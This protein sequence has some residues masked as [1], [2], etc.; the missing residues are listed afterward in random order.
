MKNTLP[1]F[2]IPIILLSSCAGNIE[3]PIEKHYETFTVKNGSLTI[4]DTLIASVEGEN[5][6]ELA[7]KAGGRIQSIFVRPGESVKK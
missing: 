4:E 3:T 7:F 1:L 6:S 2:L 5:T